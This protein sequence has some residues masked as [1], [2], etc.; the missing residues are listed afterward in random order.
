M[1]FV[2]VSVFVNKIGFVF[3]FRFYG[4][5]SCLGGSCGCVGGWDVME[6]GRMGK[7]FY[8]GLFYKE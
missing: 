8:R 3:V 5:S 1:W 2:L 7:F 4:L 6:V